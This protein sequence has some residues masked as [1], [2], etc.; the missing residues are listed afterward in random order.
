MASS[1]AHE[2]GIEGAQNPVTVSRGNTV[3]LIFKNRDPEKRRL[4]VNMGEFDEDIN[5]TAV[6]TRPKV[7]TTLVRGE[8][9]SQFL[10]FKLPKP[11]IASSQPYTF[12]VP[13]LDDLVPI[14]IKVP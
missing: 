2:Q 10:T 7:C 12:T 13:G 9:G 14:E 4:T 3:N 1:T 11:S 6:K 8:D 5:G